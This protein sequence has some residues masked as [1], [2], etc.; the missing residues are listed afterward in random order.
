MKKNNRRAKVAKG[1]RKIRRAADVN[2]DVPREIPTNMRY[3]IT[4]M[5]WGDPESAPTWEKFQFKTFEEALN[6][7][8]SEPK[9]S[10]ASDKITVELKE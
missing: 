5:D 7:R 10:I 8:N 2:A 1:Q 9:Y 3:V 6:A 4:V